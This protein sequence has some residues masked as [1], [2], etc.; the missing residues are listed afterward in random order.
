MILI[1]E[2]VM[3]AICSIEAL[4]I[5]DMISVAF[6]LMCIFSIVVFSSV[7]TVLRI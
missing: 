4:S 7:V 5:N 3:I 2:S 6:M 1:T